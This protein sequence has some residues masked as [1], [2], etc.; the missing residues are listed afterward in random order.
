MADI[1][2]E[3][4]RA[5]LWAVLLWMWWL[6]LCIYVV[7]VINELPQKSI[8]NNFFEKWVRVLRYL[9]GYDLWVFQKKKEAAKALSKSTRRPT[10]SISPNQMKPTISKVSHTIVFSLKHQNK[11]LYIVKQL[12]LWYS[13]YWRVTMGLSS[14]MG[15]QAVEKRIQWWECRRIRSCKV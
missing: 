2:R 15:R 3:K 5:G 6:I 1:N 14:L 4:W 11:H 7:K 8:F 12:M 13:M 10:K 9:W